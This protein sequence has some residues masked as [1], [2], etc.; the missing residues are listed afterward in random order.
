MV[1]PHVRCHFDST[2][3][4]AACLHTGI[5]TNQVLDI[6][7]CRTVM[8]MKNGNKEYYDVIESVEISAHMNGVNWSSAQVCVSM[9]ISH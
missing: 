4:A 8:K 9:G 3:D 7:T 2:A 1:I 6:R 5:A